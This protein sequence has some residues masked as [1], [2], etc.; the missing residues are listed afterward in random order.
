M[1]AERA[2]ADEYAASLLG[3]PARLVPVGIPTPTEPVDDRIEAQL[4]S[5]RPAATFVAGRAT[6]LAL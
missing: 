6:H 5:T 4:R 3:R 1:T 2:H